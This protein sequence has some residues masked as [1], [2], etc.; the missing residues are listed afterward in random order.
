MGVSLRVDLLFIHATLKIEVGADLELWGPPT[1]GNVTVH[2]WIISFTIAFGPAFGQGNDYLNFNDFHTLLPKDAKQ[3]APRAFL[4][5]AAMPAAP[6][7]PL[8]NVIKL[9]INQ[10]QYPQPRRDGRWLVRSDEFR[11]TVETAFPLTELDL[12]GPKAATQLQPPQLLVKDP[13]APVCARASDGYYVG[14]RP[15]GINCASSILT[16]TITDEPAIFGLTIA[17]SCE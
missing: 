8:K 12:A 3:P 9:T 13:N 5:A 10:G 4:M 16:L 11:F 15:M 2:L 1:G 17:H 14:V 7:V 6:P